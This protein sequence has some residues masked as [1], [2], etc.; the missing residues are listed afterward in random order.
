MTEAVNARVEQTVEFHRDE[1]GASMFRRLTGAQARTLG[2][3][4][5]RSVVD[6]VTTWHGRIHASPQRFMGQAAAGKGAVPAVH[7][8]APELGDTRSGV[9]DPAQRLWASKAARRQR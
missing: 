2:G 6:P 7:E 9:A 8:K 4:G 1:R 3:R 5:A